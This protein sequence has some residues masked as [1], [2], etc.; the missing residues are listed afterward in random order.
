M[1]SKPGRQEVT[2]RGLSSSHLPL[3]RRALLWIG[4]DRLA[5][6]GRRLPV[7]TIDPILVT[8]DSKV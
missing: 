2:F 1:S 7:P 5:G 4:L 8:D 6:S 3:H